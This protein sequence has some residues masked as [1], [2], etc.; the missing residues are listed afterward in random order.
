[1]S[2]PLQ[3]SLLL[4]LCLL[5]PAAQ[6]AAG[7]CDQWP[8]GLVFVGLTDDGWQTYAV[9]KA[10]HAPANMHLDTEARTPIYTSAPESL[11]Y[12]DDAGRVNQ[13]SL[14]PRKGRVLLAPSSD[15]SYAQPEFDPQNNALYL[16]QLKAGKSVDTDILRLDLATETAKPVVLQRSAQFE[17]K[18]ARDWLYYSNVHCV[19]GCGKIIQEIWRYHT[20]SGI[21]EQVTLLNT[22]SRQPVVDQQN[23]W[24]YFSSN[25]AGNYHIYRQS[26]TGQDSRRVEQLTQGAV[27]DMSPAIHQNRLYFIRHNAT[28]SQLMCRDND[29]GELLALALPGGVGDIRDLEIN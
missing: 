22:I 29:S 2:T 3:F 13:L 16:V 25:A 28:G 18:S 9:T 21:A 1:M 15:A 4:L 17:P 8:R 20:V 27:T 10:G 14:Q 12:I 7:K 11:I 26:L 19:V 23:D 24:L 5:Y 6:A